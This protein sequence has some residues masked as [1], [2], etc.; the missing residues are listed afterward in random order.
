LPLS[1]PATVSSVIAVVTLSAAENVAPL[2]VEVWYHTSV[3]LRPG[4]AT[5]S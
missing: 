1:A 4:S 3:F 5:V 2:S